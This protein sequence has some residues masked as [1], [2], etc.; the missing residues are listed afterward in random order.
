[1]EDCPICKKSL[2]DGTARVRLSQKGCSSIQVASANSQ[3]VI[4]V[5]PG[6]Y[7]HVKCR[8]DFTRPQ[9]KSDETNEQEPKRS[10]RTQ[11]SKFD[12]KSR[13]LFCASYAK[14]SHTTKKRSHDIYPVRTL[15][16]QNKIQI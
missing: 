9:R 12:F 3:T 13:C 5:Q 15:D 10:L 6:C 11:T 16:F 14:F 7:V 4:T 1:M 8:K 2:D